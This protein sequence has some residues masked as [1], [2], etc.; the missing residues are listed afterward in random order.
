MDI[1][2]F[3]FKSRGYLPIPLAL[4][5]LF[6]A[7]PSNSYVISGMLLLVFGELVRFTG[8]RYA[9]GVTRTTKVGA[10]SLCTSGPFAYVRNPLY[11]GNIIMYTGVVLIAG[12]PNVLIMLLITWC[13]FIV[14]YGLIVALEEETL[15]RLFGNEYE[16]YKENVRALIPR[17]SPWNPS[18][19]RKPM[20]IKKTI[21]TE[22]RTLQN[23]LFVL[24]LILV[25]AQFPSV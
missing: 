23:S 1:R 17:F 13:F 8:V 18:D 20:S 5:I 21:K 19:N 9:G 3:A 14:Q 2:Q 11:I 22:K 7:Q 24:I 25:R 6:F 16:L 4:V 12:A 15:T 10:P